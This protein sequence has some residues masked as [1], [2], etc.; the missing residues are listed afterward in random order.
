MNDKD[1]KEFIDGILTNPSYLMALDEFCIKNKNSEVGLGFV[2]IWFF[3][4]G[5][6][7]C[8]EFMETKNMTRPFKYNPKGE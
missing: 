5:Y 2:S 6:L 4:Q 8:I 1:T 7:A 3:T